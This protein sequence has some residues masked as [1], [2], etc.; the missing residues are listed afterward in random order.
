MCYVCLLKTCCLTWIFTLPSILH[1]QNFDLMRPGSCMDVCNFFNV[2]RWVDCLYDQAALWPALMFKQVE[3]R[4]RSDVCIHSFSPSLIHMLMCLH[5]QTQT[6]NTHPNKRRQAD[7][8][9]LLSNKRLP[10]KTRALRNQDD[11]M[12]SVPAMQ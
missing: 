1:T 10:K 8:G 6:H 12:I 3:I 4:W 2:L 11:I 5:K 7:E 9:G